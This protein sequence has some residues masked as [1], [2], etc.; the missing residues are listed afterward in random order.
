MSGKDRDGCRG[1]EG[2]ERMKI[3]VKDENE[4]AGRV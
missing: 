3:S 4:G 1:R 2:M